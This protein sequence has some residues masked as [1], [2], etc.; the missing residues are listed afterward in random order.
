MLK[1]TQLDNNNSVNR[2]VQLWADRYVPDLSTLSQKRTL[3]TFSDL[4]K[5]ASSDGRDRTVAKLQRMVEI[6]CKCA[7]I[8]A[9]V[10]FSYIPNVVSLT[11]G[12]GIAK[13]A[14]D[15]KSVV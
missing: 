9:N 4:I 1:I 3:L 13:A 10:I 6:N 5:A 14:A 8:Q 2:L 7:G 15:R 11:E 12:Q